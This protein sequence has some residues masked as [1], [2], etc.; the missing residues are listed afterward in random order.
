MWKPKYAMGYDILYMIH[1]TSS[2]K[3]H[4]I[5]VNDLWSISQQGIW[6]LSIN[7]ERSHLSWRG[8]TETGP[9]EWVVHPGSNMAFL[10]SCADTNLK[11]F[12]HML[13]RNFGC[14]TGSVFQM[15]KV[16]RFFGF[17]TLCFL[18]VLLFLPCHVLLFH[19]GDG[20]HAE[21]GDVNEAARLAKLAV[22]KGLATFHGTKVEAPTH[23]QRVGHFL[24]K[25]SAWSNLGLKSEENLLNPKH[26]GTQDSFPNIHGEN[27]NLRHSKSSNLSYF[28]S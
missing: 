23:G 18:T 14:K 17:F 22:S 26:P 9:M 24:S 28:P 1:Y 3:I 6:L 12:K 5:R 8:R 19:R 27:W 15:L 13:L 16:E 7:P 25:C 4:I 10:T 20:R 2:F 11:D 21:R